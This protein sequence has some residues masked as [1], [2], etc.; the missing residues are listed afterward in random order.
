LPLRALFAEK[1]L[2][3]IFGVLQHYRRK[4]DVFS[5]DID[6]A[7]VRKA[8]YLNRHKTRFK[9]PFALRHFGCQQDRSPCGSDAH[10]S[11]S[12]DVKNCDLV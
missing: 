4:A 5:F 11:F 8:E 12:G 1:S 2:Q 10:D 6:D 7:E 9:P 3:A